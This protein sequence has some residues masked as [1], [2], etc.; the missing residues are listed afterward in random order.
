MI[1]NSTITNNT[2]PAGQGSGVASVGNIF[3]STEVLSTI[4]SATLGTDVD[5]VDGTTNTFL[6]KGYNLIGNGSATTAFTQP[7][8]QINVADPGVGLLLDNGGP[9]QTHAL[10]AG[11]LAIDAGPSSPC[12][13]TDQRGE[14]R[15]KDGDGNATA[16]CDIGAFELAA[17]PAPPPPPPNTVSVI[18]AQVPPKTKDKTP[19]LS[20]TI[21]DAESDL[22]TEKIQLFM[23]NQAVTGFSYDA[24]ADKLS[25]TSKK[26]KKG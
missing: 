8:D 6:S 10:L 24:A 21:T 17:A 18:T 13:A 9:T 19:T 22:S 14:T 7:G 16:T 4:V 5:F 2:A 12:P 3:T 15:P 23:D 1:E 11:S 25:F 20:V 26:L